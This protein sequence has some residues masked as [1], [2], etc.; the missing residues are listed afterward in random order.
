MGKGLI[1]LDRGKELL[2]QGAWERASE[3]FKEALEDLE[4]KGDG[5]EGS[6]VLAEVL[7]K[8]AHAD[9]R[10]A[11]FDLARDQLKRAMEISRKSD[12]ESG[13]ADALRG[14]GYVYILQGDAREAMKKYEKA[15]SKAVNCNDQELIGKIRIDIGNVYFHKYDF[16]KAKDEYNTAIEILTKIG[17]KNETARAY[18]NLGEAYKKTGDWEE[19]IELL[20]RSMEL[21]KEVGNY[22]MAG[23]AA[24]NAAECFTKMG[25]LSIA[26]EY[27]DTAIDAMEKSQ[28]TIGLASSY[29]M[30]GVTY[31]ADKDYEEA[32]KVLRK[33]I[34]MSVTIGLAAIEAEAL[35]HMADLFIAK[36]DMEGAKKVLEKAIVLF[37]KMGRTEECEVAKDLLSKLSS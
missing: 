6:V 11:Q 36:G 21:A 32:E 33:S 28:D 14:L 24:L 23:F 19:G 26:K 8:K 13:L 20:R 3:I 25:E 17:D 9:S 15:L 12:D 16:Q 27:L 7:R 4:A 37:D 35:R 31:L 34:A 18:N 22:T 29:I 10:M 30:M 1:L 2:R 5:D